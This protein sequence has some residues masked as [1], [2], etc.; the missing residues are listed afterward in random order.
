M[1]IKNTAIISL[2]LIITSF[3][4]FSRLLF[5]V[6]TFAF[7]SSPQYIWTKTFGGV[8]QDYGRAITVDSDNNVYIT[9][10]VDSANVNFNTFG[11]TDIQSSPANNS[12]YFVTKYNSNNT[13]GWTRVSNFSNPNG[14]PSILSLAIATDS[15][16]SVYITGQ[17]I[18]DDLGGHHSSPN[19]FIT[20]YN[21][22]GSFGW[23]KTIGSTTQ[24]TDGNTQV[25]G[26][27]IAT[28]STGNI[29]VTGR[30]VG[31]NINFNT[32]G[33]FDLHS[34]NGTNSTA[35]GT[36]LTKFN[37]DGSYAWIR[38]F[39]SGGSGSS[40]IAVDQVGNSYIV[41]DFQGTVNFD[42]T[43]GID[44]HSSPNS[45]GSMFI[46]KYH[47]DGSYA[48]TKT[49]TD[50]IGAEITLGKKNDFYLTG[51]FGGSNVNFDTTG[52][53][54]LH[55]SN[56]S[57]DA[58]I[59]KYTTDGVYGWTRTFGGTQGES[60]N[61][62][63]VDPNDN[64]YITGDFNS[65]NANFDGTGGTDLHSANGLFD[66][67]VTRYNNDGTYGWTRTFGGV[68]PGYFNSGDG[69]IGDSNYNI[70]VTGRFTGADV[71]FNT[72]GLDKNTSNGKTD[73]FVTKYNV[74][75]VPSPT[76]TGTPTPTSTPSP[77]P[78]NI[79]MPTPTATPTPT[80][81]LTPTPTNTPTPTATPSPTATPTPKATPTPTKKPHHI[82]PPVC[83]WNLRTIKIF[84]VKITIPVRYCI[85]RKD[86]N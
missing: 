14:S 40:S 7:T 10:R 67:F 85:A 1:R 68:S 34:S 25:Q 60:G 44:N 74:E 24:T 43:G 41:G 29:Y 30:F 76:P 42:A 23:T 75:N 48:W 20:K 37:N 77:T 57:S 61:S 21:A 70:Y 26:V 62:L 8:D 9:G 66:I 4:F 55:S 71:N 5:S 45:E 50:F 6:K 33:G 38:T 79:P 59:S 84:G 47:S 58:F 81:T 22:D 73:V 27:G 53:T 35:W 52:G 63:T 19:L 39:A 83:K 80:I 17:F 86:R 64:V 51:N 18:G 31:S 3:Y 69:I 72:D 46:T 2:F 32:N 12:A 28:D 78:T 11:G 56:G 49:T 13:Y 15:N 54:D 65:T 36:F 82:P 16:R